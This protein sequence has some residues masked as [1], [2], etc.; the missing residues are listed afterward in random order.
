MDYWS[1]VGDTLWWSVGYGSRCSCRRRMLDTR[2]DLLRVKFL[3]P[4]EMTNCRNGWFHV[5][6]GWGSLDQSVWLTVKRSF[7]IGWC[8]I[9]VV[10]CCND[11]RCSWRLCL[12][13]LI[14]V[15]VVVVFVLFIEEGVVRS[16]T[17]GSIVEVETRILV[18]GAWKGRAVSRWFLYDLDDFRI[19]TVVV[20]AIVTTDSGNVWWRLRPI[21]WTVGNGWTGTVGRIVPR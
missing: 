3:V 14:G 19:V 2:E 7:V 8:N 12:R 16:E 15:N 10:L 21:R 20:G 4:M 18:W 11:R 17:I 9:D 13:E 6:F 5:V 1:S